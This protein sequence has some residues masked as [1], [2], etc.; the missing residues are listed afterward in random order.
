[1]NFKGFITHIGDVKSGTG[2]S[3]AEWKSIEFIVE[4]DIEKFPQSAVFKMMKSGE[5]VKHVDN[6]STYNKIGDQVDVEFNLKCNKWKDSFFQDL[7]VWKITKLGASQ[8]TKVE[9][10]HTVPNDNG[11]DDLPF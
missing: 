10:Q 7:Q 3:G 6:F 9:P 5:H 1:M 11:M 4:E 8:G 2:K